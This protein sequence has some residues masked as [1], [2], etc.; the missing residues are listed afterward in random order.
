[1]AGSG[2]TGVSVPANIIRS[3]DT[4]ILIR[5][6]GVS[7]DSATLC[8][9]C[10]RGRVRALD[11]WVLCDGVDCQ[12]PVRVG[13]SI[14]GA[15]DSRIGTGKMGCEYARRL[16]SEINGFAVH[17]ANLRRL[18]QPLYATTRACNLLRN[19]LLS[20]ANYAQHT[21]SRRSRTR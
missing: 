7:H 21:R 12:D 5:V 17:R 19:I 2:S 20:D 10:I 9:S 16:Q 18:P 11:E 1:M 3:R 15:Q 13:H 14:R 4:G 6:G 8:Q